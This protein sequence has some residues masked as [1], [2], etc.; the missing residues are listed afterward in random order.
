MD[1][2]DCQYVLG[3]QIHGD[4]L[5][6]VSCGEPDIATASEKGS[7]Q[8]DRIQSD[9]RLSVRESDLVDEHPLI[10]VKTGTSI[11]IR[12]HLE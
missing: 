4:R 3:E 8:Q 2:R 6:S 10:A 12:S 1:V 5:Y 9:V 7:Y 11:E